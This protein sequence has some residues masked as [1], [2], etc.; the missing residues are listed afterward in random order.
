MS[1]KDIQI[2]RG[3]T[4]HKCDKAFLYHLNP[5]SFSEVLSD[6]FDRFV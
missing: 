2:E 6:C 4:I 5:K 1:C 3:T